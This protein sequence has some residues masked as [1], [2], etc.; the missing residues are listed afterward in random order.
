[1]GIEI[2]AVFRQYGPVYQQ[3]HTLSR[4]QLQVIEAIQTCRT[5]ALGG[6]VEACDTCGVL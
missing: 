6:H 1:M 5:A 3:T 4:A 2:Q